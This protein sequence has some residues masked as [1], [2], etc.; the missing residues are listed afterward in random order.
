VAFLAPDI[1]DAIVAVRRPE[2]TAEAL[3]NVIEFRFLSSGPRENKPSES[4]SPLG[5]LGGGE[6]D[7][8]RVKGAISTRPSTRGCEGRVEIAFS[9]RPDTLVSR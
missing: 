6:S 3:A 9:L 2:L 8:V 1:V 5:G 4:P 7:C